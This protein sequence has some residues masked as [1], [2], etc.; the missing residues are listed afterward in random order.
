MELR[1]NCGCYWFTTEEHNKSNQIYII[2]SFIYQSTMVQI[3]QVKKRAGKDHSLYLHGNKVTIPLQKHI[4]LIHSRLSASQAYWKTSLS[5]MDYV[6]T[7]GSPRNSLV[8]VSGMLENRP[9]K[10]A[11]PPH[12][13]CLHVCQCGTMKGLRAGQSLTPWPLSPRTSVDP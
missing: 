10:V 6:C 7:L 5:K 9:P 1:H 2:Y 3:T 11:E 8:S 4:M 13:F 12:V